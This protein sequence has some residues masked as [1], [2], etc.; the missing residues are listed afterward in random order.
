LIH[1]IWAVRNVAIP[2]HAIPFSAVLL[3]DRSGLAPIM[4]VVAPLF[5]ALPIGMLLSN[6]IL[7]RIPPYRRACDREPKGVWHASFSDSQKDLSLLA[8]CIGL[9]ALVASLVGALLIR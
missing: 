8:L 6:F 2:K 9:P 3:S 7:W 4:F 5:A 1:F